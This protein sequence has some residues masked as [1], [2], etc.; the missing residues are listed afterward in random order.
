L[1]N[2]LNLSQ[3]AAP[4]AKDPRR[5]PPLT[6]AVIQDDEAALVAKRLPTG[7]TI[8]GLTETSGTTGASLRI[9]HTVRGKE[10][11][12]FL[13]QRSRRWDRVDPLGAAAAIRQRP[14]LPLRPDG[15]PLPDGETLQLPAWSGIGYYFETGPFLGFAK[16]NSLERVADWIEKPA[17]HRIDRL[18]T[19]GTFGAGVSKAPAAKVHP[20]FQGGQ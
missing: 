19:V 6:K 10:M 13:E 7:G 3:G 11:Y 4:Q 9:F 17:R 15:T 12:Q 1:F 5:I 8:G 14:N 16:S 18:V 2:H 20:Q